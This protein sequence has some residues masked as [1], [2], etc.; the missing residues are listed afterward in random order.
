MRVKH[1]DFRHKLWDCSFAENVLKHR[2]L[3]INE[4]HVGDNDV[5]VHKLHCVIEPDERVNFAGLVGVQLKVISV[6]CRLNW[7]SG[8]NC[9]FLVGHNPFE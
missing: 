1:L 6:V 7:C 2:S 9:Q 3:V 8:V 4:L 5:L